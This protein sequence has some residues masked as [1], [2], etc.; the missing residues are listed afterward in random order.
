MPSNPRPHFYPGCDRLR[1][2]ECFFSSTT[3]D[4]VS[5]LGY[6]VL[7]TALVEAACYVLRKPQ[8]TTHLS[9]FTRQLR[10]EDKN[11]ALL[12][13]IHQF[14]HV[15]IRDVFLVLTDSLRKLPES[16]IA[17]WAPPKV[18]N[19]FSR[20]QPLAPACVSVEKGTSTTDDFRFL[21]L[22]WEAR[23]E[24]IARSRPESKDKQWA[25]LQKGGEY[26]PYFAD[27]HLLINWHGDGGDLHDFLAEKLPYLKG[28]TSW[29]L[30]PESKHFCAGL[31]YSVRTASG[32]SPRLLPKGC[33]FSH[34]G[35]SMFA[36]KDDML[37]AVL[38]LLM[39]RPVAFLLELLVAAGDAAVSGSAARSYEVGVLRSLP[40]P[41][42][43]NGDVS[44][45]SELVGAVWKTLCQFDSQNETSRYFTIPLVVRSVTNQPSAS[46]ADL[47]DAAMRQSETLIL[48]ALSATW[49]IE[50]I[51]RRLYELDPGSIEEIDLEFGVHP[52]CLPRNH[53]A[54]CQNGAF[55]ERYLSKIDDIIDD[56][57]EE[58]GGSRALTKK[59][60]FI[61]RKIELLSTAFALHPASVVAAR[62]QLRLMTTDDVSEAAKQ[63]LSYSVGCL[64]G[65]WDVTI[66][67][68]V[69][70]MAP[71]D[72]PSESLR[73]CPPG[74]L[75]GPDDLPATKAPNDYP[76][77]IDWDGIIPDDPDHSEDIVRRVREVLELIWKDRAEAIE[78]EACEVL[79][80]KELRDYFRKP[81][82]GGFWDDHVSRYSKS[83]RK[84]PIYW[85]LQS[86]K[87]NYALWLYYHRLDKD[88]LF[89][90]RQN[91]VEPKIRLEQSRLDSLRS[92]KTALGAAKGAKKI[93]KDIERQE[94]LLGELK[95]FAE[96]LERAAKLNF[97]NPEKLKS[98]VVYDPDLNDGVVL[99]IAPLWELV[100]WKE[101]KG[102]WEEL[103]EGKY[104]WS[105]MG[106]L[107]RRKGLVK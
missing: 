6:G 92:Q 87:K 96:K 21:R 33:V 81:G 79:G 13:C 27:I 42:I 49:K 9:W 48:D 29:V 52:T 50:Q 45:T 38:G 7:D 100:P 47:T 37:M 77:R 101:A 82:K 10:F 70:R 34:A 18:R 75:K 67:Q 56:A 80:V 103:L 61:D 12:D 88:I 89:K 65:R 40:F 1:R 8:L 44:T 25:F 74:M 99:T 51:A 32:F 84:A 2:H 54:L 4:C 64:F 55:R 66:I 68:S 23:A 72:A 83:R 41:P 43:P 3:L 36:V 16:R 39:S 106:K 57:V 85:L 53:E 91:Y 105:S 14:G 95:D 30:H 5:D 11:A 86:S 76:I 107:L 20:L 28:N 93:D 26:A 104:E 69:G 102:Y 73:P 98:E 60:F 62:Q 94:A 63:L 19:A 46:L 59:S 17:Y 58:Q 31:T 97:G 24:D 71:P 15:P 90:A 22:A 78:K 35:N